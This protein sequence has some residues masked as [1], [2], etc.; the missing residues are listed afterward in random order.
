MFLSSI[1]HFSAFFRRNS[2]ILKYSKGWKIHLLSSSLCV[3]LPAREDICQQ[4][5]SQNLHKIQL[6]ILYLVITFCVYSLVKDLGLECH[7]LSFTEHRAYL[8]YKFI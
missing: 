4:S 2:L 8:Q 1:Y 5:L 3:Y 7:A 6:H